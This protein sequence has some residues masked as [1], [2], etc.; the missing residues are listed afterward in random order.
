M[1]TFEEEIIYEPLMTWQHLLMLICGEVNFWF[2]LSF[3]HFL[4]GT[5]AKSEKGLKAMWRHVTLAIETRRQSKLT[6]R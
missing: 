3:Y 5:L 2:G 6:Q 1:P 4:I